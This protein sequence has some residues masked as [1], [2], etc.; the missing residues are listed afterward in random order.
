MDIYDEASSHNMHGIVWINM[1]QRA[2]E[3]FD[4]APMI[5]KLVFSGG[6]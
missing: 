1:H 2:L 4:K 3:L 5:L 6:T